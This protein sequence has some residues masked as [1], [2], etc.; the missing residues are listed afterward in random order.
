MEGKAYSSKYHYS[1]KYAAGEALGLSLYVSAS[2][3]F[4]AISTNQFKNVVELCHVDLNTSGSNMDHT[5]LISFLITNHSLHQKKFEKVNI[6]ILNTEFTMVPDAFAMEQEIKPVLQFATGVEQ[7]KRSQ[8]HQLQQLKFFYGLDTEL[9]TSLE[10]VF[11]N[12]SIRHA[13]AAT[14]SLLFSQHS[15]VN[16]TLYLNVE[17]GFI[18]LAAK[19]KNNL[20]FYNVFH[21]ESNEDI[22]Y[23]LLFMME[24][25][26]LNPLHIKLS[27]AGQRPVSD[28]LFKSIKK[29][30]KQVHFCVFDPSINL[31][32][33]MSALPGHYYFTLLNQH[34]C[35]L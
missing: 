31:N 18:E 14:V 35:E 9:A 8:K 10:R 23:Y 6:A 4:Y 7:Q 26:S 33:D 5:A 11:P 19:D 1:G 27:I 29:Y 15:L 17:E 34:L 28:D 32:G 21:Y 13:G 3:F 22:L 12:A 16:S 30:I 2:S 20:L 25:F 24:Q